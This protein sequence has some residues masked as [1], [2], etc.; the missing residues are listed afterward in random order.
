[1]GTRPDQRR[2]ARCTIDL[3]VEETLD[4]ESYLHPAVDLSTHG[5]YI[6]MADSREAIDGARQLDLQFTL[7]GGP[8]IAARGRVVHVDDLDGRRG[9]HVT[10]VEM[11]EADRAAVTDYVAANAA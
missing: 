7:P 2:S 9:L 4:G 3:F 10:F 5:I 6:L 1:M 11:T 8:D